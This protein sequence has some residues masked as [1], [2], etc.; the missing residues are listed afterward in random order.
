MKTIALNKGLDLPLAGRPQDA[1]R[2][3]NEVRQVALLGDDYVGMKPTMLVKVDDRVMLGQPLFHD[4]G[5]PAAVFTAPGCGTV[6][7][8]NRGEK[9][10]FQSLVIELDGDERLE[11]P[12]AGRAP[13]DCSQAELRE[14]LQQSGLW[15]ALRTRPYGRTPTADAEPASL[16]VTAIDSEPLSAR[17]QAIIAL[18]Q[19]EY[20]LG[21]RF[22]RRL[23][24]API[25]YC[26][27]EERLEDW[28][29]VEGLTP[30][31]FLG[32]H[33]AG[34]PSTHIHFIDPVH[35]NR[36]VWHIGYQDVIAIGHL[37]ASGTLLAERVVALGGEGVITPALLRTRLGASLP[38]L[39]RRELSLEPL[40]I[41]S[42][43]LL[44]GRE[45]RE[46][47]VFL[48]R[49]HNQVSVVAE[50]AG[51]SLF[52]WLMPGRERFSVKP[53]FASAFLPRRPL[54]MNTALWGGRR[55]IYPLGTYEQVMP[56]DIIATVLLKAVVRG[57]TEQAKALGCLELIEEDLGPLS[58]VCPGKNE[59]GPAL[60]QVLNAIEQGN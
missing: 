30:W 20:H 56:L 54:P 27:G 57:D 45:C 39:C 29:T 47:N 3:G 14:V 17:P 2:P 6:V 44:S 7:A 13:E 5:N 35:E 1:L 10:R 22:L 43:S 33:P 32:P 31:R 50:S 24:T 26:T 41:V 36:T 60:R 9:R 34:L 58:F 28:E 25:H 21:L 19:E 53:V 55:A 52:N 37:M 23:V 40:R 18:R 59:F 48:G 4:K 38:D 15:T 46:P 11:F 42:G 12:L 8:V 51:R 49:Y 16:F